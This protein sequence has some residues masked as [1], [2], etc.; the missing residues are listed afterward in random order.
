LKRESHPHI[1]HRFAGV[2]A[3]AVTIAP[4]IGFCVG[5]MGFD[6]NEPVFALVTAQLDIAQVQHFAGCGFWQRHGIIFQSPLH[7]RV[8]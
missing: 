8:C 6:I 5:Q 7:N 3:A 1:V 2:D 4:A